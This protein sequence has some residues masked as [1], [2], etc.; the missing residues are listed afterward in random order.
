MKISFD[1]D[2]T[3]TQLKVQILAMELIDRGDEVYIISARQH[4]EPIYRM[5]DKL[6]IPHS[7]VFAVG[8]NPNKIKKIEDLD[9]QRHYDDNP[10][11]IEELGSV[12]KLIR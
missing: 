6:G 8:S 10:K 1:Y 4:V 3:L 7:R 9:I 12:G 5:A 11:V 2:N